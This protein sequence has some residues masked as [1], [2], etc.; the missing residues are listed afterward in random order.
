LGHKFL[1][2][3]ANFADVG[4]TGG[5]DNL[6]LNIAHD[7]WQ[8]L[9]LGTGAMGAR[10]QSGKRRSKFTLDNRPPFFDLLFLM[11]P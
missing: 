9:S 8:R 4:G 3:V 10:T 2:G 6:Q 7:E 5:S 1:R 11:T